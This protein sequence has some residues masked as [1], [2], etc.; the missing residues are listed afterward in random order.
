MSPKELRAKFVSMDKEPVV[1]RL[2]AAWCLSALMCFVLAGRQLSDLAAYRAEGLPLFLCLFAG[3]F[4]ALTLGGVFIRKKTEYPT[5]YISLAAAFGAY[6]LLTAYAARDFWYA[7]VLSALWALLIWYLV[8]HGALPPKRKASDVLLPVGAALLMTAFFVLVGGVGALRVLNYR[9]PNFDFGV[10]VQSFYAMKRSLAPMI[11]V[12]RDTLLSHFAVHFSPIFYLFLPV[13]ALFPSP[14]TLQLGQAA[15]LASAAIPLILICRR[16]GIGERATLLFAAMLLFAPAA[17]MGTNYDFHENC[18]LLPLILW[19][20]WAY[21]RDAWVRMFLCAV[22][23]LT[24]KEDAFIYLMFFGLYILFDRKK[25]A[26]G[27][28]LM[29][30]SFGYFLFAVAWLNAHGQGVMTERYGNFLVGNE[31]LLAAVKTVLTDPGYA[32]T[33]IFKDNTGE[34]YKKLVYLMQVFLPLGHLPF[35]VKHPKR[36]MLLFPALLMNFLTLYIYQYDIG[37]Q[38]TFGSLAFLV[39]LSAVNY[40]EGDREKLSVPLAAGAALCALTAFTL[41]LP[42]AADGAKLHASTAGENAAIT[43]ALASIPQEDGVTASTMLIPRLADR[44]EVYEI[45]YHK[46]SS[47]T[48]TKWAVIDCRYSYTTHLELYKTWGYE[49]VK[50]YTADE[51]PVVIV[52][53]LAEE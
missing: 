6:S 3:A 47:D 32:F 49:E 19:T 42:L 17:Y 2:L 51:R 33:Q 14:V 28:G 5:H 39:Y 20:F 40:A 9:A 15:A 53:K 21:E 24:V 45:Y 43:E 16:R 48:L 31:G 18:F 34:P 25:Y 52:L 30:L 44:E 36:L 29:L 38:Y 46:L 10:F 23:T 11:T 7:L 35:A 22:L 41:L 50:T 4:A 13:F 12:E 1:M 27:A 37:F 8:K 26:V